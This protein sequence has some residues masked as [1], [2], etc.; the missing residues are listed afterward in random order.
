VK[1][2]RDKEEW[3]QKELDS[4]VQPKEVVEEPDVEDSDAESEQEDIAGL[5]ILSLSSSFPFTLLIHNISQ[6]HNIS[7]T[8]HPYPHGPLS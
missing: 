4:V 6:H 1:K 7:H 3:L 5:Q 2:I 8:S